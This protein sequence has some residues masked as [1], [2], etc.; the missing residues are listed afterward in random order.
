MQAA[1]RSPIELVGRADQQPVEAAPLEERE[2]DG[3]RAGDVVLDLLVDAA[4]VVGLRP[5]ALLVAAVDVVLDPVGLHE[6]V[7]DAREQPRGAAVGEQHAPA[8]G[9][10]GVHERLD[11]RRVVEH[12]ARV[13]RVAQGDDLE[14]VL[15]LA[16]EDGDGL[17]AV[18]GDVAGEHLAHALEVDLQGTA[19][20]GLELAGVVDAAGGL[21]EDGGDGGGAGGRGGELRRVEVHEHREHS[22][23]VGMH[24]SE[25]PQAAAGERL[26]AMR[27]PYPGPEAVEPGDLTPLLV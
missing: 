16:G 15:G 25:P 5:A 2:R 17:R 8:L 7:A 4:L 22:A 3:R 6:L 18:G 14:Q 27:G 26:A 12:H 21:G 9:R 10:A 1:S 20:P 24:V 13:D 23:L 19:L 11:V